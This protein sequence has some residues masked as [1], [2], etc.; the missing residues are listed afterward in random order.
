VD[1]QYPEIHKGEWFETDYFKK[2]MIAD[3]EILLSTDG[4]YRIDK[5]QGLCKKVTIRDFG[6]NN[7]LENDIPITPTA[8]EL[9][10]QEHLNILG[11]FAKNIDLS[12][13]KTINLPADISFDDFKKLYGKIHDYGVKGCTTYREGTS[14]AILESKR[15][16][17]EKEIKDQQEEFLEAFKNHKDGNIIHDIIKL[18]EEYP[19]KGVILRGNGRK[20]YCHFSFMDREM[21]RPFAC[22]IS[23]NSVS[24][25]DITMDAIDEF[26]KVA[27]KY[28]L[29]DD[30]LSDVERKFNNQ[31]NHTK[32]A[33]MLGYLLRHGVPMLDI[34]SAMGKVN[35]AGPGTLIFRL[36]KYLMNYVIDDTGGLGVIC[37]ECG[38]KNVTLQ[39]GCM[40][41]RDCFSSACN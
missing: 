39:E 5:N 10:V 19:S 32:I 40:I 24:K 38:S 41:C 28:G 9:S 1:F 23:T 36:K 18:P 8:T 17:K 11:V 4:K 2:E 33:R 14:V 31:A 25:T 16:E 34:V 30:K 13:S 29:N 21:K 6:Y 3:E 35:N 22:F 26:K 15:E 20:W 12:C 27:K 37:P 7:A